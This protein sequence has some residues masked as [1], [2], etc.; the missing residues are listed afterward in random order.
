[1]LALLGPSGC[2]K[3]STLKMVAGI[4]AVTAGRILF[5]GVTHDQ[6]EAMA[7]A[8]C[9]AVMNDGELQQVGS[10][11]SLYAHPANRFVAGFIGESPMNLFAAGVSAAK[12]AA[13]R[14]GDPRDP[15]TVVGPLIRPQQCLFIAGQI[16][17]AVA[18]GARLLAGGSHDGR[19][20]A[21]TVLADV[22]PEMAIC[23][24][25]SFGPVTSLLRARDAEH[26]L[27]IANDTAYR[28]SSANITNDLQKAFD[29]ALRSESGMVPINDTTIAD[30]PHIAF[31]GVKGSGFGREGGR[32]SMEEMTELKSITV[33]L[34]QRA[35][36]F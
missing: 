1:M 4:E 36:P 7:M 2:G 9:V 13:I 29:F 34:G 5:D 26:A 33:Q 35:Y 27:Q 16:E 20:F 6:T 10:P 31:G 19:S 30:E 25:E 21:P 8:D 15:A 12:A 17:A 3:S 14:V 32:A 11:K 22:T 18:Q 28:L 24:E 23:H